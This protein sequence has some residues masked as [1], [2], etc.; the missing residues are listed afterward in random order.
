MHAE[1]KPGKKQ[2]TFRDATTPGQ[3]FLGVRH[4]L[5]NA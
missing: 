5:R 1:R 2:P 4:G 3:T